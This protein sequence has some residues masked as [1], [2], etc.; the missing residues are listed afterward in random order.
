MNLSYGSIRLLLEYEL[1]LKLANIESADDLMDYF[2]HAEIDTVG[3]LMVS[4]SVKRVLYINFNLYES[5]SV[6][7]ADVQTDE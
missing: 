4:A 5:S 1:A 7:P 2:E 3:A 6:T